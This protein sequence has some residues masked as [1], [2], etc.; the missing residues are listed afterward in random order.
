M[1]K[2]NERNNKIENNNTDKIRTC[3]LWIKRKIWANE[4]QT[5]RNDNNKVFDGSL[6]LQMYT[7]YIAAAVAAVAARAV[8]IVSRV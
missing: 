5:T 2:K 7:I 6:A 3:E 8:Q 4:T 1:N